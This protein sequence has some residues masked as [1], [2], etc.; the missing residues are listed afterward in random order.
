MSLNPPPSRT[1]VRIYGRIGS[2]CVAQHK[3]QDAIEA[4]EK[5]AEA[6]AGLLDMSRQA[7]MYND[8]SI[9]YRRLGELAKA[10]AYGHKAVS[11]HEL[12]DDALSVARAETNLAL[13]LMRRRDEN[14]AAD[15]LDHALSIFVDS[16]QKRGRSHILLAQAEVLLGRNELN[17][18]RSKAVEASQLA[19]EMDEQAS[20]CEAKQVLGT[21]A[22]AESDQ[23]QTDLLFTESIKVLEQLRLTDPLTTAHAV[24][25]RLLEKR[26]D[27]RAALKHWRLAVGATHPDAA[28]EPIEVGTHFHSE[29]A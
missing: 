16:N 18:A 5:A 15:S 26:G 22:A 28:F 8:L 27:T 24:Y 4:Y 25:A 23:Q 29:T 2:I 7:K 14:A 20:A 17:A 3:W 13:I 10:E 12:L 9:A 11:V 6:G 21:I 1:I 19:L